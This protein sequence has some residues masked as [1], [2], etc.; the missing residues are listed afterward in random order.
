M[1]LMWTAIRYSSFNLECDTGEASYLDDVLS[2]ADA[3]Q[4]ILLIVLAGISDLT[5]PVYLHAAPK[6]GCKVWV[7]LARVFAFVFGD[8]AKNY[9]R[10]RIDGWQTRMSRYI[11]PGVRCFRQPVSRAKSCGRLNLETR[12]SK[13]L[14]LVISRK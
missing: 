4:L 1:R 3:K 9:F 7:A 8:V 13:P 14:P 2:K 6:N 5:V 11:P 12:W 10:K